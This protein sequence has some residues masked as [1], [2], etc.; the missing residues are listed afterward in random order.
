MKAAI[1]G[2]GKMGHEIENVLKEREHE[3]IC[4]LDSTEELEKCN[5]SDAIAIDFTEPGSFEKN[6]KLLAEKFKGTVVGT[7]GWNS[8]ENDVINYFREKGKALVYASNFSVGVNI[9]FNTLEKLSDLTK[10]AKVYEPFIIEKH[11]KEKKDSPSGT[12]MTISS[13]LKKYFNDD[14]IPHSVRSGII[15]GEH[16]VTF[17]SEAD[18]I[19]LKHEAYSRKGFALGAILAAEWLNESGGIWNF[20]DLIRDKLKEKN[21]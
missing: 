1:I 3:V 14:V 9:F 16:E 15:K 17:E 12:A 2:Y 8:I 4:R 19:T 21:G 6:Y 10:S 20:R 7:T 18:R 5:S 13:I 11:H